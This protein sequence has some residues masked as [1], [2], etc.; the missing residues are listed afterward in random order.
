MKYDGNPAYNSY[1]ERTLDANVVYTPRNDKPGPEEF[2]LL[3]HHLLYS[4]YLGRS[5]F[6]EQFDRPD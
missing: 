1:F 6:V 3:S 5:V 4:R 2:T